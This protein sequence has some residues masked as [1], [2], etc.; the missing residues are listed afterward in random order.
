MTE[1]QPEGHEAQG[2]QGQQLLGQARKLRE[3]LR[4]Q[5]RRAFVVEFTGTPKAGKSTSVETLKRF[6]KDAGFQVHLLQ[7]RAAECPLPMK[8]HFFFNAWTTATML[9]EVLETH[10]T[11]VDLLILDRG[12]FDALIWLELQDKRG[13]LSPQEKRT[14]KDFVLLERWRSL[15]DCTVLMTVDPD[16]ALDR[17]NK[18]QIVRRDGSM[19]NS[20]ALEEFNSALEVAVREYG[21]SFDLV[22]RDTTN[23]E[24]GVVET[25]SEIVSN[26]VGR[27]NKWADPDIAVVSKD[28][29]SA[30]FEG[31][32]F[33]Q[34]TEAAAA[35]QKLA[36]RAKFMARSEAERD[37]DLVQLIAAGVHKFGDKM[38]VFERDALDKKSTDY[39]QQKLWIG[40]HVER[41]GGP[42]Q[43]LLED[44][45]SCL[46]SRLAQ[47]L[48]LSSG[49]LQQPEL[50]G[51]AWDHPDA[52]RRRRASDERPSKHLGIMFESLIPTEHIAKHLENKQFRRMGRSGRLVT[53]FMSREDILKCG[54]DL[55]LEAWSDH[56]VRNIGTIPPKQDLET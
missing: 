8:G 19:M 48:H 35:L 18:N 22:R 45:T 56:Y 21:S 23:R 30:L 43:T 34:G 5:A 20:G 39:G 54:R 25:T 40:C 37:S 9:A 53:M 7:E 1:V 55:K 31:K 27:M 33:L 38:V 41:T 42:A 11:N 29:V 51:L 47:E 36:D 3:I 32:T 4:A 10:E 26:L 14:F 16:T 13:Q 6:F 2:G 49:T 24:Q 44:A 46:K 15:V 50:R 17:E 52:T 12:F 28:T